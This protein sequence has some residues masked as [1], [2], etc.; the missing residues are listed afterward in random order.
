MTK[1]RQLPEKRCDNNKNDML[2]RLPDTVRSLKI[3]LLLLDQL[4]HHIVRIM[5][6]FLYYLQTTVKATNVFQQAH[7]VN[8]NERA[9][10]LGSGFHG[11]TI[12]FTGTYTLIYLL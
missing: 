6:L 11:C 1:P 8:R 5:Y 3:K 4:L 9:E 12:W 10:I 7:N 2:M